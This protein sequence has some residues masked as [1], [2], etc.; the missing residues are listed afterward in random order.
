MLQGN[1]EILTLRPLPSPLLKKKK[2]PEIIR[3]NMSGKFWTFIKDAAV[4]RIKVQH[5]FSSQFLFIWREHISVGKKWSLNVHSKNNQGN[6]RVNHICPFWTWRL[7]CQLLTQYSK[8]KRFSSYRANKSISHFKTF[9]SL[10][11][12]VFELS[13]KSSCPRSRWVQEMGGW[14][15]GNSER[16]FLSGLQ[17]S[18]WKNFPNTLW[19]GKKR[20][21]FG[22]QVNSILSME[23]NMAEVLRHKIFQL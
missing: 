21:M 12:I 11:V 6:L 13:I 17:E 3:S 18:L 14:Q 7:I 23:R 19:N 9:L 16:A 8:E 1:A 22:I 10:E 20:Q 5:Y 2:I 15:T 4:S